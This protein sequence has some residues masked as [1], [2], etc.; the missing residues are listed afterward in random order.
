M[1]TLRNNG[2]VLDLLPE[3]GGAVSRFAVDGFDVLRPA[4][5]GAA[6]VLDTACF[7]LVPF[8]NR[9]ANGRFAFNGEAVHLPRNFGDHPHALHGQGW[10]SAWKVRSRSPHAATLVFEHAAGAWPWDYTATQ[11]FALSPAALGITLDVVNRGARAM[12][13]SLGFHPYFVRAAGTRLFADV[14]GVWLSDET[15]IPTGPAAPSHFLDLAHGAVL[16]DAPFVDHCHFGWRRAARIVSPGRAIAVAATLDFLHVF[17]PR[18]AEFFCVEPVSAM[19]DA[20]GRA[21][22]GMRVLG[23]GENFTAA[24]TLS[25][26]REGSVANFTP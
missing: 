4:P 12:P 15:G 20:V 2:A 17:V 9:I 6:G 3:I 21:A 22:S 11:T 18:G 1:L 16:A 5:Q 10:Q 19:P 24:M 25:C 26:T 23:P 13:V 7:P 8:S 14:A